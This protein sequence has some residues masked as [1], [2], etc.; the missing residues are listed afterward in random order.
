M[1]FGA[2]AY[3]TVRWIGNEHGLAAKDTWSKSTVDDKA[4]TIK[5]NNVGGYTVGFED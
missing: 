5:S 2:E 3:T 1:L 4:N